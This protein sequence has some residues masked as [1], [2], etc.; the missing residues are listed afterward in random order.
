MFRDLDHCT[1]STLASSITFFHLSVSA[2]I[3]SPKA[4]GVPISG[5]PPRSTSRALI[6]GSAST[7]DLLVQLGDDFLRGVLWHP[8]AEQR[9]R[10]VARDGVGKHRHVRQQRRLG[11]AGN[12]QRP[13]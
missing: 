10:L 4:S 9:T 12:R 13:Y 2:T 7:F 6:V 3:I 11:R 5:S 8:H 1:F